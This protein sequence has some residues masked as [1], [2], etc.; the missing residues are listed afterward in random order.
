MKAA[1][2][3]KPSELLLKAKT[4]WTAAFR[5]LQEIDDKDR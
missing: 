2:F 5:R 1:R 3:P 4:E